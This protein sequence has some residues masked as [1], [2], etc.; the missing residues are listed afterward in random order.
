MISWRF[1]CF[2]AAD[3]KFIMLAYPGVRGKFG[4]RYIWETLMQSLLSFK[5]Q[6]YWRQDQACMETNIKVALIAR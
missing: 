3:F 4:V 1:C 2:S 6:R 5:M